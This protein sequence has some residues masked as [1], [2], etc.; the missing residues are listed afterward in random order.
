MIL[1]LFLIVSIITLVALIIT[2]TLHIQIK[3]LS[4]SNTKIKNKAEYQVQFALYLFNKI[5]WLW[6]NLNDKK[7]KK[8]YTKMQLEKKDYKKTI[9]KIKIKD[10]KQLTKLYPKISYLNANVNI[11][12]I[13]PV[14]TSLLVSIIAILISVILPYL[15]KNIKQNTYTYKINPLYYNNNLYKINVNC[16]IEIKMVHIINVIY[17]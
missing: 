10:L 12:V 1:V 8:M 4:I 13:D 6:F 2:S 5:K 3:N 15:A 11:G 17:V 14:V 16:I 7:A 9:K